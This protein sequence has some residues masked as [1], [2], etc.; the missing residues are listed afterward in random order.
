MSEEVNEMDPVG[1]IGPIEMLESYFWNP[2]PIINLLNRSWDYRTGYLYCEETVC[3]S[4]L[5]SRV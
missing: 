4:H 3:S 2:G 5:L 1:I